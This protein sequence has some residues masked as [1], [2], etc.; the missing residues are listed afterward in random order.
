MAVIDAGL[1]IRKQIIQA[2]LNCRSIVTVL[3]L[4][5]DQDQLDR[6]LAFFKVSMAKDRPH[7]VVSLNCTNYK[8][9]NDFD[10]YGTANLVLA[11]DDPNFGSSTTKIDALQF[12]VAIAEFAL[13]GSAMLT[14]AL[15][16]AMT[17]DAQELVLRECY[18]LLPDKNMIRTIL[19]EIFSTFLLRT[20]SAMFTSE[21]HVNLLCTTWDGQMETH[22]PIVS[23]IRELEWYID[24]SFSK[25]CC[26][27]L[28][29]Q[30]SF[31]NRADY[32]Y[33]LAELSPRTKLNVAA[34]AQLLLR[35][36]K[37][38]ELETM[39]TAA[40]FALTDQA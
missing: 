15:H 24:N 32:H 14:Q 11:K 19:T 39:C 3:N 35:H 13:K 26:C 34:F 7:W 38:A 9:S 40:T 23:H 10:P 6:W 30:R 18:L 5:F 16:H 27:H 4:K 21:A 2:V 37:A 25:R 33:I 36:T 28:L 22:L 8:L 31:K 17:L 1:I 29:G 12:C 20:V